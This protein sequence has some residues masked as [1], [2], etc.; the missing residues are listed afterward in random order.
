MFEDWVC[1][2]KYFE[3]TPP[4]G[5]SFATAPRLDPLDAAFINQALDS[6]EACDC[7]TV[8]EQAERNQAFWSSIQARAA[9]RIDALT[10]CT[11]DDHPADKERG[12]A[13]LIA[14]ARRRSQSGSIAY[15]HCMRN[16]IPDM[17]YL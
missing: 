17:P 4:E 1:D 16:L 6:T 14:I 8:I 10:G 2:P 7:V 9:A 11:L 5:W 12:T 15:L 13:H 3:D